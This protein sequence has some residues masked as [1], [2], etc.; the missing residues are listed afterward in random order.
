M[1]QQNIN[2]ICK[3]SSTGQR[4][5]ALSFPGQ[6]FWI[7]TLNQNNDFISLSTILFLKADVFLT[8][9]SRNST[10][11]ISP[12]AAAH[13][14]GVKPRSS[15]L[16]SRGLS[17]K[18]CVCTSYYGCSLSSAWWCIILYLWLDESLLGKY[19]PGL[20]ADVWRGLKKKIKLVIL[21]WN[22]ILKDYQIEKMQK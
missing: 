3:S 14:S 10:M 9:S 21:Y 17:V 13:I 8:F 20:T 22:S 11:A 19:L 6:R 18:V 15:W 4:Q 1:F 5:G 12:K 16:F 7:G 2:N